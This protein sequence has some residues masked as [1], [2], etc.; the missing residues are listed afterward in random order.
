M[1]HIGSRDRLWAVIVTGLTCL[2]LSISRASPALDHSASF[3][4]SCGS[5]VSL[6]SCR[7]ASSSASSASLLCSSSILS[8]DPNSGLSLFHSRF[9]SYPALPAAAST[10]SCSI[11]IVSGSAPPFPFISTASLAFSWASAVS[12]LSYLPCLNIHPRFHKLA[13]TTFP[14][15]HT[16]L[17]QLLKRGCNESIC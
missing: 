8:P 14:P 7:P 12:F 1:S 10:I 11:R 6:L 13:P 2:S 9:S 3:A 17:S 5:A 15:K 4:F 16:I